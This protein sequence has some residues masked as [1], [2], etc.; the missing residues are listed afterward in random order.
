MVNRI[1]SGFTLAETLI[2]LLLLGVVFAFVMGTAI[3]QLSKKDVPAKLKKVQS[4]FSQVMSALISQDG[5]VVSW[6]WVGSKNADAAKKIM[7]EKF[8]PKLS[9]GKF[10]GLE[11]N[12]GCGSKF[13]YLDGTDGGDSDSFA[14]A[15]KGILNDGT[16]IVFETTK[17]CVMSDTKEVCGMV[18]ADINGPE[19]P[20]KVGRDIFYFA[21]YSDSTFLPLGY[22]ETSDVIE[23]N[24]GGGGDGKYCAAKIIFDSWDIKEEEPHPYPW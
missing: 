3:V 21:F 5:Y 15:S 19:K 13:T 4:T 2:T 16:T 7:E 9:F 8:K 12:Q 1:R 20:N 22:Y 23:K 10:C 14:Y 24:C 6:D 17:Q 18:M 11:S